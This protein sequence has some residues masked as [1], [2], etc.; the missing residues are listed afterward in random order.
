MAPFVSPSACGP[1]DEEGRVLEALEASE[2]ALDMT[3]NLRETGIADGRDW[4]RERRPLQVRFKVAIDEDTAETAICEDGA[5]QFPNL[6][7]GFQPALRFRVE[8]R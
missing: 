1:A 6:R 5:A 7:R 3:Q 4:T 8:I 2:R